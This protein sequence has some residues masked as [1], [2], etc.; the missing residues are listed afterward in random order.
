MKEQPLP[1]LPEKKIIK[2]DN[3]L[4]K[5][6]WRELEEWEKQRGDDLPRIRIRNH[7]DFEKRKTQ[8]GNLQRRKF[9]QMAAATGATLALDKITDYISYLLKS[10][11]EEKNS[12]L[13][14]KIDLRQLNEIKNKQIEFS[15]TE[16]QDPFSQ[17]NTQKNI[18]SA[19][20]SPRNLA[21][22]FLDK[23]L[24]L[25]LKEKYWPHNLFTPE[26][27]IAIQIQETNF[28]PQAESKKHAIGIMQNMD[29]SIQDVARFLTILARHEQIKYS[30]PESFT[31]NELKKIKKLIKNNANYSRAFGKLFLMALYKL[32]NVGKK[33][34]EK[35][36][37]EE[38][39][40]KLA[41][42]YN[43]GYTLNK[44]P[45]WRWPRESRH[46]AKMVIT[47][48]HLIEKARVQ[49]KKQQIVSN[50]N[51]VAMLIVRDMRK[52]NNLS[53]RVIPT[54]ISKLKRA[55]QERGRPL[56]DKELRTMFG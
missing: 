16:Q 44:K 41:A 53:P 5:N 35:G 39:Q 2:S 20:E 25:S 3:K 21:D 43:G 46:Y 23:Y 40:K 49:L 51:Y 24:E 55:E 31:V 4:N 37:I 56:N 32:Y 27:L 36:K 45:S 8:K 38:A 14:K 15:Q 10:N 52:H 48:K 6:N 19:N 34:L 28:D 29:I 47:Y 33:E 11:L 12:S 30:G 13:E 26:F 9:I 17:S 42:C 50:N 22:I 54:Y 1:P 18:T 7:S